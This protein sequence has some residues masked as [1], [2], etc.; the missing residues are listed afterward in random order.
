MNEAHCE[1]LKT[2]HLCVRMMEKEREAWRI[3][4]V[5]TGWGALVNNN[6]AR[7]LEMGS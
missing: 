5:Y 3:R 7:E 4:W 6:K 1:S 2:V